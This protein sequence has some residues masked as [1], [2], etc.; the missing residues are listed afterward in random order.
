MKAPS[1][2]MRDISVLLFFAALTRAF[3]CIT[4]L[5]FFAMGVNLRAFGTAQIV[6]FK[7]GAALGLVGCAFELVCGFLGALYCEEPLLVHKCIVW[8]AITLTLAVAANI[9]Q[10]VAGYGASVYVWLS[11]AAVPAV[12]ILFAHQLKQSHKKQSGK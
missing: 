10:I 8:G 1:R 11:G 2:R 6:V 12:Y 5:N 7:L 4:Y 9:L 3:F